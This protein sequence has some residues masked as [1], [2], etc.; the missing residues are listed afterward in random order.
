MKG[1]KTYVYDFT[2]RWSDPEYCECGVESPG[3]IGIVQC[4]RTPKY[5]VYGYKFCIQHAKMIAKELGVMAE[6]VEVECG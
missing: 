3:G 4:S 1:I 6:A 2:R 5:T